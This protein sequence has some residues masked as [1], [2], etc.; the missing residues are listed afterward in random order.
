MRQTEM[1]VVYGSNTTKNSH[2]HHGN[3]QKY[4]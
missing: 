1:E 3:V 2:S 4:E